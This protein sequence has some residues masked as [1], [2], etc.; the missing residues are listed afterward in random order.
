[1]R[2]SHPEY[3]TFGASVNQIT[4]TTFGKRE[5]IGDYANEKLGL[6]RTRFEQGQP[7]DEILSELNELLGDS[8]EKIM[9]IKTI[10]DS[11]T[12]DR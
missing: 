9:L 4:M 11:Q 12:G 2:V 6:L 1:M 7:K 10:L 3:N 8:V 5:T